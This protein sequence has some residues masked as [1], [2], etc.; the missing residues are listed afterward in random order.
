MT[1]VQ[2][3]EIL[4]YM[5]SLRGSL[6]GINQEV[7]WDVLKSYGVNH[8]LIDILK[9]INGNAKAA[10]RIQNDLGNWFRTSKGTR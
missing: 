8:T 6:G 5:G 3:F 9:N 2:T 4:E 7:A 1:A 10:V